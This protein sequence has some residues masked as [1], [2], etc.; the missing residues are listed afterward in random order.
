MTDRMLSRGLKPTDEF[1]PFSNGFEFRMWLGN[2]CER[3]A[4]C[5][6]YNPNASSSRHGCPI[7]CALALASCST[8]T[9][10]AKIGL[11]GG[12]LDPGPNGVLIPAEGDASTWRCPEYRGKD[13]PD[14]KPRR[15]PQ[16]PAGQIDLLDPR[17]QPA[18]TRKDI[19]VEVR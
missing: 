12:L 6:S 16:P 8:G 11:R 15:G 1:A 19:H 4:G 14:D 7:E 2:N 10:K 5:R 13:E 17:N 3:G 9:V 18:P